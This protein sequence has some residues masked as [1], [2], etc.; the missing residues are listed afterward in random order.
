MKTI[1]F[2]FVVVALALADEQKAAEESP[3]A[4]T[5]APQ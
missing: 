2:L 3:L 5:A 4:T 1:V